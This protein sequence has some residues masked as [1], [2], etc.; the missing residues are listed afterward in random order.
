MKLGKLPFEYLSE[1]LSKIPEYD[2][3]VALGASPGED[4][5]LIDI[6]EKYLVATTDPI[7]FATNQVGWYAVN[8]NAND[9]ASMGGIPKWMMANLLLPENITKDNIDNIFTQLIDACNELDIKLIGGHTEVTNT[10]NTPVIM[11][12]MLGEVDKGKEIK[13]S[14]AMKED[15]IIITK[16]IPIEGSAILASEKESLLILKGISQNHINKAKKLLKN[17]GISIVLD[18]RVAINS[19]PI[20]AMH[21][22]TEGGLAQGLRELAKAS[23]LGMQIDQDKIPL[24]DIS[25]DFW[26]PLKLNPLG[27]IASGT[28]I[29]CVNQQNTQIVIKALI[30][31]GIKATEIGTMKEVE[32]GLKM[33][34]NG[35]NYDLPDFDQDEI[36][37]VFD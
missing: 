34:S 5:A 7:T 24:V 37:K 31:N 28:L 15:S 33:S 25:K 36:T 22:S 9:I 27:V 23:N 6:G 8:V 16:S 1:I 2:S 18:A 20:H 17:P 10:V 26:G 11:G 4:A 32:Y 12:C 29:I 19:A 21:D 35:T 3:R 13:S 14:G 30:N